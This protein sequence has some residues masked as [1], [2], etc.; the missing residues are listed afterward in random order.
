MAAKHKSEFLA[1]HLNTRWVTSKCPKLT[2]E[3]IEKLRDSEGKAGRG[4]ENVLLK[5][6]GG[7][8]HLQ[9]SSM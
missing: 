7:A 5:L 6:T 2:P 4:N 8:R 1:A 9:V 3:E